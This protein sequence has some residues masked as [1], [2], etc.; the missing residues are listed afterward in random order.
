MKKKCKCPAGV[1]DWVMTY[2]DLMSLLLVFFVLIVSMSEIKQEEKLQAVIAEIKESFGVRGGGGKLPTT[3]DPTMSEIKRLE[4]LQLKKQR[5]DNQSNT[6]DPGMQ[7]REPM[8]TRVR[9]GFRIALGG[10]I[11]FEPG[12]ADLS[13]RDRA[14]LRQLVDQH[15]LRGTKNIIELRGHAAA[16]ELDGVESSFTDLWV[17]SYARAKSVMD[18]L[19]SDGVGLK[20]ERFR[21]I[22]NAEREPLVQRVYNA[23]QQEPN[24]R[25]EILVSEALMQDF[26]QPELNTNSW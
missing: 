21:L 5:E 8:V 15:K 23:G 3:D 26:T 24:R 13:D 2:G 25:V 14:L 4:E 22:A 6:I 18:Y 20:P 16:L 10:R 17:L 1:P 7:G 11:T 19:V 9:E 12:S